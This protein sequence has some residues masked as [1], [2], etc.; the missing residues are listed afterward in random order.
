MQ[1]VITAFIETERCVVNTTTFFNVHSSYHFK[2][3]YF[4]EIKKAHSSYARLEMINVLSAL[5][6]HCAVHHWIAANILVRRLL[7]IK[8]I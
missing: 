4:L 3:Q 2:I 8:R 5:S 1:F 7:I 6:C